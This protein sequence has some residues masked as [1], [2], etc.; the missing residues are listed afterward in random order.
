MANQGMQ[1]FHKGGDLEAA[2]IGATSLIIPSS[3]KSADYTLTQADNGKTFF[4]TGADKV[5]TLPATFAGGKYTFVLKNAGLSAGTG[6]SI[7]PASVDFITGNGLTATDNKDL[8]L[9]GSGDRAGDSVTIEGDGVD[10]WFITAIT[11][12]WS[13]ES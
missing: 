12:T 9:A 4:I 1:I 6:L 13:K 8:I 10:G 2:A 5:M 3:I 11:G 7:S